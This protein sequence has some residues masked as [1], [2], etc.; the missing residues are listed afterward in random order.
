MLKRICGLIVVV[1]IIP[2]LGAASEPNF[3]LKDVS[4][5]EHN[6]NEYIGQGKWVVVAIWSADC[7]ICRREIYHMAFFH[8]EHSKKDAVVLGVSIDGYANKDKAHGFIE[9]QGLTFPNLIGEPAAVRRFGGAAFIGTPTYYFFSPDG[10][11][12]KTYV[13]AITQE[14]AEALIHSLA[15]KGRKFGS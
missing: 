8:D 10:R 9:A 7:P 6:V 4:G 1:L 11:I 5:R 13:G 15:N 3:S 12:M 14:Q 2:L